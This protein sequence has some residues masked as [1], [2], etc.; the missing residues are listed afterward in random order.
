MLNA[1]KLAAFCASNYRE[2]CP[3]QG[4]FNIVYIEGV[5]PDGT[6]NADRPNEWNDL[7]L[8]VTKEGDAWKIVH[9]AIATTEP[10]DFYTKSPTNMQGAARIAFGYHPPAW[11]M[12]FHK[13]TQPALVQAGNVMI[14]RD[15]N[16]DGLR[17]R[18]EPPFLS[19]PI[20]LNHHTTSQRFNGE[21]IGKY[22]AG[23]LVGKN[24]AQHLEFLSL[25]KQEARIIAGM[26]YL[27][28]TWT[29]PGDKFIAS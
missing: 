17:G 16:R 20:G 10:G 7:R 23:C 15:K 24:Y 1:D 19:V 8:L 12:G 3:L 18:N 27:Y 21:Q 2:L 29:V 5:N 9:L 13:G 14:H 28:D 11:K 26:P 4:A 22:S 25:L 6:P